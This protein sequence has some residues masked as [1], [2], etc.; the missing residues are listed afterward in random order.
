MSSRSTKRRRLDVGGKRIQTKHDTLNALQPVS[1]SNANASGYFLRPRTNRKRKLMPPSPIKEEEIKRSV[2]KDRQHEED[3]KQIKNRNGK[4]SKIKKLFHKMTNKDTNAHAQ[5]DKDKENVHLLQNQSRNKQQKSSQSAVER[6]KKAPNPNKYEYDEKGYIIFHKHLV[7]NDRYRV[8]RRL[9]KGTFSKVFCCTDLLN[10][11]GKTAVKVIRNQHKYQIAARTELRILQHLKDNDASD[12]YAVIKLIE[13]AYFEQ[14]PIFVF[15]L[16]GRSLYHYL[17]DN[18]FRPF[19]DSHIRQISYQIIEAVQYVHSLGIIITDLKPENIIICNDE[20]ERHFLGDN[21]VYY[22]LKHQKVR[23]IDFGS[24]VFDGPSGTVH[25]HLIQTRH[26]RA[27]EV[28]FKFNW[29]FP[30]DVWS[31]GCVIVELTNGKMLFNTHDT[32]DHL[33]Q[34]VTA[35]GPI[36]NNIISL[37]DQDAYHELFNFD[38]KLALH[39]AK[40]S[41]VQCSKLKSYFHETYHQHIYDLV[42][43]MLTWNPKTRINAKNALKHPL[44]A[45]YHK[46]QQEQ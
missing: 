9:G 37:I 46:Q 24:A 13:S 4:L 36:P 25:Q 12:K 7:M 10:S 21:S 19:P 26:Y 1:N 23:L 22:T 31:I 40:I 45:T 6:T 17:Y 35:I 28:M 39:R 16:Y 33:N 27:P 43:S 14:H 5:K 11:K 2:E 34:I 38:G 8:Q 15:P 32:I 20:S 44:F 29:S 18:N 3:E 30:A 42:K 41:S